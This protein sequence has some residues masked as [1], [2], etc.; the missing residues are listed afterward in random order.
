MG[1]KEGYK[2][3]QKEGDENMSK[4]NLIIVIIILSFIAYTYIRIET[5][6]NLFNLLNYM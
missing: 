4:D 1:Q 3:N 2:N 5:T 6:A